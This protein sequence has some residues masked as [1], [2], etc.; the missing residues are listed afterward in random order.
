MLKVYYGDCGEMNEHDF[1]WD[2]FRKVLK[3]DFG[4]S[5]SDDDIIFNEHKKP[6]LKGDPVFFNISH[7]GRMC[8]VAISDDEVGIDVEN[9]DKFK[10]EFEKEKYEKWAGKRAVLKMIG[11][12]LLNVQSLKNAFR[13]KK[14]EVSTFWIGNYCL[15]VTDLKS[16]TLK[17]RNLIRFR[18]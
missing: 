6:F 10:S 7:F 13:H 14:Y 2:M 4:I 1:A 12:G 15:S 3:N 16:G 8:A 18:G 5:F 11:S 17:L 9:K